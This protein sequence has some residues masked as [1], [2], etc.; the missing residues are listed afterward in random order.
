V[1]LVAIKDGVGK[2]GMHLHT[3][4]MN[5]DV[6]NGLQNGG[7]V[8]GLIGSDLEVYMLLTGLTFL[9]ASSNPFRYMIR[10]R[11]TTAWNAG[12]YQKLHLASC[13]GCGIYF[14]RL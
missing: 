5:S 3:Y 2:R 1:T 12:T 4:H 6:S 9:D 11:W 14:P 13:K 10:S 8:A 7:N